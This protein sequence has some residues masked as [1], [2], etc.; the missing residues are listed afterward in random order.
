MKLPSMEFNFDI[1]LKGQ[2]TQTIYK[3]EFTYRRL[4]IGD[5]GKADVLRTRLNGD[6]SN[7][8]PEIDRLHEMIG[9]L[10]F[11]IVSYPD[12]WRDSGFGSNLYDSNVLK[13][14]YGQIT[15]FEKKW[16]KDV[17]SATEDSSKEA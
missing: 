9:W 14:V 6:L 2:S 3:G 1:N 13:D 10:R 5:Q 8:D 12:W 4:S 11:G 15:N 16:V 17:N 7:V